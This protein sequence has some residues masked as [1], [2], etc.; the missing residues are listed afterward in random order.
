M[1]SAATPDVSGTPRVVLPPGDPNVLCE[2]KL[3]RAG[4]ASAVTE[5][6]GRRLTIETAD[7]GTVLF[8][9]DVGLTL[10][11]A[12]TVDPSVRLDGGRALDIGC[13]SGVYT[14]AL[15]S[16]G[17]EQV[18]ALDLNPG[19]AEV[20]L[21]NV[22]RNGF[23]PDRV[24]TVIGDLA[25]LTVER[26][27][28]VVVCNP[29]H[30]PDDP[31]YGMGDG[32]EAALVGGSDGRALY[33]V[34]MARLDELLAPGGLL[35]LTHSS[36]TDVSR[37]RSELRQRGYECRTVQVCEL[38][39]P[40]RR[41][42]AHRDVLLSRLYSLRRAGRAAFRGLRFEVHT[43]AVTRAPQESRTGVDHG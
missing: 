22:V 7:E 43:L 8:P 35:L 38:D 6:R 10:L 18:T 34:V 16:G 41:Y 3:V 31:A 17:V 29:P 27:W 15:L 5:F 26:P 39:I 11:K 2:N 9:T 4:V 33:D 21:A 40:L 32:I 14:V 23:D 28:D 42:A 13:G 36:L 12:L 24:S 19:C 20:T 25:M 37:T 30:F 1:T